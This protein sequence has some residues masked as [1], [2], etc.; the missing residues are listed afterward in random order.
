MAGEG[1]QYVELNMVPIDAIN[2]SYFNFD[3]FLPTT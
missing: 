2:F 1:S 3:R